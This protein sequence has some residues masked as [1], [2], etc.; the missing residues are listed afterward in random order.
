VLFALPRTGTTIITQIRITIFTSIA[1]LFGP[2][3]LTVYL[4]AQ[5]IAD[6]FIVILSQSFGTSSLPPLSKHASLG[7]NH[8]FEEIVR[9]NVI[10]VGAVAL[11]GSVAC[12]LFAPQIIQILYGTTTHN[13]EISSVFRILTIGLPGYVIG[14]YSSYVFYALKDTKTVF[15]LNTFFTLVGVAITYAAINMGYGLVSVAYGSMVMWLTYI[16]I[17]FFV[18]RRKELI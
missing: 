2:G 3:S 16:P 13:N 7:E 12:Y 9:K 5:K 4:F 18:Y 17:S 10:T 8:H 11:V 15:Y 6:A 14:A 1:S